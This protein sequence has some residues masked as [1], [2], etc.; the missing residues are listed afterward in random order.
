MTRALLPSLV[1]ALV[2][3]A[4]PGSASAAERH[5]TGV[6]FVG[7]PADALAAARA[8]GKLAAVLHVAGDFH[9]PGLT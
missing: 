9:D 1:V 7:S 6:D 5:G 4:F 3:A 8:S 2:L